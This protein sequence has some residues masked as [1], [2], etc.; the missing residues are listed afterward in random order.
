M[1]PAVDKLSAALVYEKQ[2][3]AMIFSGLLT[4]TELRHVITGMKA[5]MSKE[6]IEAAELIARAL[7]TREQ[8]MEVKDG[9]RCELFVGH[10]TQHWV[11]VNKNW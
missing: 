2:R 9:Q 5:V 4:V 8:C 7:P 11:S 1:S 10:P 3:R 6:D